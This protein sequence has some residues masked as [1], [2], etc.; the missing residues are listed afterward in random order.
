VALGGLRASLLAGAA[1]LIAGPAFAA[2]LGGGSLKD[3][4]VAADSWTATGYVQGTSDYI[5]RGMSQTRRDPAIQGGADIGYGW[6]YA[7]TFLSNVDFKY[8][9][10]GVH[11]ANA[12]FDVYLGIKP[13]VGAVTLDVGLITYNYAW[14]KSAGTYDPSFQ[15]IKA[16]ASVTVLNDLTV[17]GTFYWSPDYFGQVGQV[18]TVEGTASKPITKIQGVD[19][20]ASGTIGHVSFANTGPAY[21][22]NVDYTYGNL[23][24]TGTYKSISLDLRWWDS[25][26][27][28]ALSSD[29]G[30]FHSG[31]AFA[32]T[33]KYS[34]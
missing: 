31:N 18:I 19:I 16:G 20:A 25:D 1:L 8:P 22:N 15:E 33:L 4:P 5:F 10:G 12:E 24:V 13:K 32:G 3:A 9:T 30:V 21:A 14:S 23:G 27:P 2:D 11:D 28:K 26:Y 7:G 29:L 6:F 34:F 17:G